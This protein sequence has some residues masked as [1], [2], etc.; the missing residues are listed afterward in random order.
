MTPDTL[1]IGLATVR[2]APTVAERLATANR[3]LA[4]AAAQDVAIVCFPE[5][6]IPGLRG[7]DFPVPPRDQARQEA[8]LAALQEMAAR[9]GVAAVVGM[10]WETELGAHNVAVVIDR[11]GALQGF[12]AKNP[13]ITVQIETRGQGSDG[14]NIVKTRLA[15]GDMPDLPGEEMVAAIRSTPNA[16]SVPIILLSSK[17]F[18]FDIERFLKLGVDRCL[19]K[20]VTLS[21]VAL[22]ARRLID[23]AK[24]MVSARP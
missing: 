11:D 24:N 13:N 3:M 8:A 17:A 9:R 10:E 22:T 4:E 14:D 20:P 2:N 5:T 19:S 23:E 1:R 15:T 16:A 12:Q 21:E 18:V 7:F 6:Y